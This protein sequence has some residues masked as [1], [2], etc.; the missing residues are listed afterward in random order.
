MFEPLWGTLR[1]EVANLLKVMLVVEGLTLNLIILYSD[2]A[3]IYVHEL[4]ESETEIRY[5][6]MV[7][8]RSVWKKEAK[9]IF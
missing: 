7:K 1:C 2:K 5:E 8:V 4:P 6:L 3:R 9:K